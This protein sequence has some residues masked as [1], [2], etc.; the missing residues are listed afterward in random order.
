MPASG[1]SLVDANVWL[2]LSYSDHFH[3]EIARAW[4]ELQADSSCAFCRLTQ[5]ALLRHLTNSRIM[6]SSVQTQQQAWTVYDKLS[7]DPRVLFLNEPPALD[8]EFRA[9]SQ[10]PSP[11]HQRWTD[12]YLAALARL[13]TAR[14]ATFDRGF[15]TYSG[16]DLALLA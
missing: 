16:L 11:S 15:A 7:N 9:L 12:A 13:C 6:G 3:H 4:F 5:M 10:S 2:A 8:L 1:I 14:I